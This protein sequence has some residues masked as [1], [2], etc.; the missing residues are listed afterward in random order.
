[1]SKLFPKLSTYNVELG[2]IFLAASVCS[3]GICYLLKGRKVKKRKFRRPTTTE[4][5][6]RTTRTKRKNEDF[7]CLS[8][9]APQQENQRTGITERSQISFVGK[10]LEC[11]AVDKSRKSDCHFDDY[12]QRKGMRNKKDKGGDGSA[13]KKKKLDG[14]TSPRAGPSDAIKTGR[15]FGFPN[16]FRL[17]PKKSFSLDNCSSEFNDNQKEDKTA[18]KANERPLVRS[19]TIGPMT[20]SRAKESMLTARS[21]DDSLC[22]ASDLDNSK[23]RHFVVTGKK[24]QN[25]SS[26]AERNKEDLKSGKVIQRKLSSMDAKVGDLSSGKTKEESLSGE[27][28]GVSSKD[29]LVER[30]EHI[31]AKKR[32]DRE[33]VKSRKMSKELDNKTVIDRSKTPE[34]KHFSKEILSVEQASLSAKQ[35]DEAGLSKVSSLGKKDQACSLDEVSKDR[36]GISSNDEYF[37]KDCANIKHQG[38]NKDMIENE[39]FLLNERRFKVEKNDTDDINFQELQSSNQ[40]YES[41][42]LRELG[43]S[44]R[45]LVAEPP[46]FYS[47]TVKCDQPDIGEKLPEMQLDKPY[48][49]KMKRKGANW[50]V[51]ANNAIMT[52]PDLINYPINS[53]KP[54]NS[55]EELAMSDVS[56]LMPPLEDIITEEKQV[57]SATKPDFK[58]ISI[59]QP[60]LIDDYA[61]QEWKGGTSKAD[62]IRRGYQAVKHNTGYEYIRRIRGDN[63]CSIRAVLFKTL[64]SGIDTLKR[65]RNDGDIAQ[66]PFL[67]LD[68]YEWIDKWNFAKRIDLTH[69]SV[70]D[71][72]SKCLA[73]LRDAVEKSCSC[74]DDVDGNKTALD[75]MNGDAE[76][77]I[78]LFEAVK[79][80]MLYCSI[81]LHASMQT[82]NDT[83]ILPMLLFARDT[84]Q[85]PESFMGNHLNYVGDSAGFDQ[86]E[87]MLLGH[88][89]KII[90]KSMRLDHVDESD[91]MAV[92][93]EDPPD[94]GSEE[95]FIVAEDDR[96]YNV[97][98]EDI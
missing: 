5:N 45:M 9:T 63:Y 36:D 10:V 30:T 25:D 34:K 16:F 22:S 47:T 41:M 70:T 77:E 21:S 7:R 18:K 94:D 74:S 68:K 67:L 49:S 50:Q 4:R 93:S 29:G 24:T 54:L 55:G 87:M 62:K 85:D 17:K 32:F 59:S 80:L 65:F 1:M 76:I 44:E 96:H 61:A 15:K 83:T 98:S 73:Q 79:F 78:R 39:K 2:F 84:S 60:I 89:L 31:V 58:P 56:E 11:I 57:F 33:P 90:I 72:L 81:Q 86:L 8:L 28:F 26:P 14:S 53:E 66:L 92:F 6:R 71:T 38:L 43:E 27:R 40:A 48:Q 97:L 69:H 88:T 64:S 23:C 52:N 3:F 37:C 51:D 42:M 82:G 91:F 75:L 20:R 35:I 12:C 13:E 46:K 95:V 19:A